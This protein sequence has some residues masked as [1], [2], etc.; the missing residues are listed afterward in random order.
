MA[1]SLPLNRGYA[2]SICVLMI[3][4]VVPQ[5]HAPDISGTYARAYAC[6]VYVDSPNAFI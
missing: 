2:S 1:V 4:P 6:D 3:L 5:L